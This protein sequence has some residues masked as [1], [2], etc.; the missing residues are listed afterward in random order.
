MPHPESDTAFAICLH[1]PSFHFLVFSGGN[2]CAEALRQELPTVRRSTEA[3]EGRR[4]REG[5]WRATGGSKV[6]GRGCVGFQR[7]QEL[8]HLKGWGR[9]SAL[10]GQETLREALSVPNQASQAGTSHIAL[11]RG[12][13][14]SWM[15]GHLADRTCHWPLPLHCCRSS[16]GSDSFL[17]QCSHRLVIFC[18]LSVPHKALHSKHS[19]CFQ[20]RHLPP[21]AWKWYGSCRACQDT[22][23]AGQCP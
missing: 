15:R 20:P 17:E 14:A 22:P 9:D 7:Q 18:C 21:T 12:P 13:D 11:Q 19:H 23:V 5:R 3:G 16:A 10:I 8:P 1:V 6:W 2:A 4:C